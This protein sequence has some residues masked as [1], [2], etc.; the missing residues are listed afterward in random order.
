MSALHFIEQLH[1]LFALSSLDYAWVF[2]FS[3]LLSDLP[4][5]ELCKFVKN[6][7][8]GWNLNIEYEGA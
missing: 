6:L 2:L 8:Y 4:Y 1:S 5:L 7:G 3:S